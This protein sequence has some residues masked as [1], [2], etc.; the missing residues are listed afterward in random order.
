MSL[1][2]PGR[3]ILV[4]FYLGFMACQDYFTHFVPSQSLGGAKM[5]DS[6]ENPPGHP[7]TELSLSHM[8]PEL[9]SNPQQWDERVI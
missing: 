9:D 1:P 8:W 7:Q 5:A 2:M 3:D 6:R 4:F